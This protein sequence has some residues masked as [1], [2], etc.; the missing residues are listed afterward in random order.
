MMNRR[1]VIFGAGSVAAAVTQIGPTAA[2][3]HATTYDAVV[4]EVW[5]P[6]DPSGGLR[7][8]VRAATLAANSHNTQPWKFFV[9]Q[10]SIAIQPDL[11]RRCSAVDPDDHHLFASLGCATENIVQAA[12]V[13]GLRATVA[14]DPAGF[15]SI[16]IA[17]EAAP[18]AASHLV[19]AITNRQCT[20]TEYDGK[21]V[22]EN[23]LKQLESA[24][25]DEGVEQIVITDSSRMAAV[26]DYVVQGNT[27]QMR[28]EAFMVEL[29]SWIR[30][31]D[32]QAVELRD[33]LSSRSSGNPSLPAWLSRR[34]LPFVFTESGE[35]TKYAKHI[36]SS[37]GIVVFC[38]PSNDKAGWIRAGRSYQRFALEATILGLKHAFINQ[39]VEVPALRAQFRQFLGLG[40]RRPDL[41]VR[42]G[43]GRSLPKSLRRPIESVIVS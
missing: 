13:M 11:S 28:D 29:K 35:N 43:H 18:S 12:S 32:R 17:L 33:G 42:F 39:P 27:A 24:R 10:K 31:N 34:L 21:P 36:R 22:E 23:V 40:E 5:A 8:L 26:L 3:Q 7:E 2:G 1:H 16:A 6:I 20:R 41:L 37:S 14:F 9:A 15:G 19:S 4:R 38:A 25:E 30:F